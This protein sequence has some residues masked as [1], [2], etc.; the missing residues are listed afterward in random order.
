M[1]VIIASY[2]RLDSAKGESPER[3]LPGS[4]AKVALQCTARRLEKLD[5]RGLIGGVHTE[6]TGTTP[7]SGDS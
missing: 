1:C 3:M 4:A 7:P 2:L 5:E 6:M